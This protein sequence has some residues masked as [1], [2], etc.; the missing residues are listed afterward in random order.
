MIKILLAIDALLALTEAAARIGATIQRAR[1][2][3]RDITDAELA[4]VRELR[5]QAVARLLETGD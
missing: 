4:Q 5:Q 2:E 1:S 3:G